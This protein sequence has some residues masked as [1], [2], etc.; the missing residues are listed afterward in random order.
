LLVFSSLS[1]HFWECHVFRIKYSDKYGE[2]DA[3]SGSIKSALDIDKIKVKWEGISGEIT[4]K[5]IKVAKKEKKKEPTQ[6][7]DSND[8]IQQIK[9]LNELYKSGALT[10]EQFTKAK[11]KLLN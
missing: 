11:K 1:S 4:S 5:K 2:Q 10:K 3:F 6:T 9:D 8:I 7:D